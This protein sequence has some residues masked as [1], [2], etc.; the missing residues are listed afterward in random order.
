MANKDAMTGDHLK[1]GPLELNDESVSYVPKPRNNP[2][3]PAPQKY[4]NS[5]SKK[6]RWKCCQCDG[7]Y[8]W[9]VEKCTLL[10][11]EHERCDECPK[12]T[13]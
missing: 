3:A 12:G 13:A 2:S 6:P 4:S 9:S 7:E 8:P 1:G 11:C 10:G 5:S